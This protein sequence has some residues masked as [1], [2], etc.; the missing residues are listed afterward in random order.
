MASAIA[1][2]AVSVAMAACSTQKDGPMGNEA[3]LKQIRMSE[4]H[5]IDRAE[6]IIHQAVDGMS[7]KPILKPVG[8]R[9]GPCIAWDD[10]R[11]DDRVQVHRSYQLTGV[12]GA[13]AK[14]L[15][16]QARDAWVK[17]GY[18]F[19]SAT[20]D[21]D[22]ADPF[23]SVNMR[24]KPDDFSVEALTGVVDRKTGDGLAAITVTSPCFLDVGSGKSSTTPSALRSTHNDERAE[25]Q[26]LAHSS[27]IYDALRA[28]HA[29]EQD[30]RPRT[31]Q[32]ADGTWLHHAWST[33]PLTEDETFRAMKS[34]QE[35]LA[36]AG[37]TVRHLKTRA[38]SSSIV[39]RHADDDSI[40][41]IAPSS[42]G[43]IRVAVTVPAAAVL[44]TDM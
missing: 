8:N 1:L 42:T 26:V 37:W 44:R 20:A 41:Q 14:K 39:A 43:A 15:V 23:P 32:D 2:L 33:A 9:T 36:S 10:N 29:P 4:R 17:Q 3:T 30:D 6:E 16:R 12:P 11:P 7:P 28:P 13:E 34:A 35:H 24:S 5:A 25:R 21:G 31:V 40:A 18:R 38:G 19:T 27:R 22:W